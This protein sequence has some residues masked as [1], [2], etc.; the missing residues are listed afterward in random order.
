[1][2]KKKGRK[3]WWQQIE[4]GDYPETKT[5]YGDSSTLNWKPENDEKLL[6]D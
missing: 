2:A 5:D 4:I 3:G 6:V 1:M